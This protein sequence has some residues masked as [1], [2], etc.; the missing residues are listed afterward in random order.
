MKDTVRKGIIVICGI[1]LNVVGRIIAIWLGLP[2][3]FDM[4]GTIL[5]A[6]Y[7]GLWG[8]LIAGVSN[9]LILSF[10][11]RTALVYMLIS[12]VAA[13]LLNFFIKKGYM[14][15]L[16]KAV[17]SSFWIG[18][19]CTVVSTP[20]N[21]IFYNGYS[22]NVWGDTLVDMLRWY[23]FPDVLAALAGETVV[24]IVDK[25][26]TVLA[27]YLVI[28]LLGSI[29]KKK[30]NIKQNI[31][32]LL[33]VGIASAFIINPANVQAEEDNLFV[34]NFVENIYDSKNGMVSSEANAI[35]ET[36]DG[37]IWIGSYAGLTR[38]NGKDFEFVR[39]GGLV[40]VVGM[41]TDS[42]GRL[43]I[44]TNDA[45]I[46]RY[47]NGEYTYFT[48]DDGL[49]SDSVRCFAEDEKGNVYVGT[50]D[51]ICR[52][53]TDDTIQILDV[54][55]TFAKAMEVYQDMLI[56]VDNKGEIHAVNCSTQAEIDNSKT[57]DKFYY[58]LASTSKGL[59]AGTETGELFIADISE[60]TVSVKEQI[61]I[62]GNQ[63]SAVF[64]DSRKRLWVALNS[65]F[66]YI[67]SNGT[68]HKMHYDGFD[69]SIVSFHED[70][71]GNIWVASSHYG[72]MKLSE[73][74]FVNLFEKAGIEKAYVNAVEYFDGDYYCAMDDGI[75]ILDGD[76]LTLK[77]NIASET[78][79]GYRVRSF[80]KDSEDRLWI[81]TYSGL[82]CYDKQDGISSF[83]MQSHNIT[84]ERFRCITQLSDG[85]IAAGTA[86]GINFIKNGK[87]TATFD[88]EDGLANTQ[89][90]SIVE[91]IDGT[92]WAG[93]DG[94]GIY[95][96]SEGKL[97]KNYTVEDGLS[98]NI[99]LRI[100][101]HGDGYFIVTSNALCHVDMDGTIRR[102]ES[103]PY[104]NNY[105]V[106]ING[107]T[108]YVTCSAGLYEVQL[109]KLCEDNYEQLRY[110]GAGTGLFSGLTANSWNYI[111]EDGSL[112]LCS[113]SG[114]IVYN[115]RVENTAADMKYGIVSFECD[116][117]EIKS[118]D[119]KNFVVPSNTKN[120]SIYASVKN[121]AFEEVKVR[122]YIKEIEDNPKVCRWDE[123]ESIRL[124]KPDLSE[125][126]VCL[127]ILD[128]SGENILQETEYTIS[129][130]KQMWEKT[131]YKTYLVLVCTEI[132]LF[133]IISIVIMILF[134]TR[135]Y[136]LEK[137]Q[138]ELEQKV[139]EQTGELVRKQQTIKEL[140][141]QTVTALSEAV[142][143]KDRYTSG[144]SKR[145][146]EY[147]RMIA[148]RMGK[149]KEEQ[150]L[151]YRAGLLH[152]V[153]KIRIP[154]EIINKP[155]KLTDEEYNIMK[156]HP[157]TG[158]HI[159]R[160]ITGSEMIAI[161][162]KYHHERYDGKGYPNGLIGEKIPE[163]AR[164][165]GIAD[166]Y[167]AMTSNR[168]YRNA[169]PQEVVRNEIVKGRGTQF[170]P[171]VAD[172]M[173]QM[174]DE[175]MDYKLKQEEFTH[176]RILAVDDEAMNNRIIAHIMKEEPMYEIIPASSGKQALEIIEQQT[177]DLILLDV[178]MPEMDGLETLRLIRKKYQTPVVLMTADKTLD[179]ST[180][181]GELGCDDFITKPFLPLLLKEIIHNM[182][183]RTN[184]KDEE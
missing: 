50:S 182:T 152:D 86:D 169:L 6:Y 64:E 99:I 71:Q 129:K 113:N 105:D 179:T 144:H 168:S 165:L 138:I 100:V 34:D 121:Y 87:V 57:K 131:G 159:L 62:P 66:G 77:S 45:G 20:L 98:S 84:S 184:I 44:G 133:T 107:E 128:A 170:D 38:Y 122:F 42:S 70:Y 25:Q 155:G 32:T 33:V 55:I 124:Y 72:V 150:E 63:I 1:L 80:Y 175:D 43:W 11:D 127:Q 23:D 134:I 73:S 65:D 178:N 101:P 110:Y 59:I 75:K 31:A 139:K 48:S 53:N 26:I 15:N 81:C 160:G 109:S 117:K 17:V 89:I 172:I 82:F 167:D 40:N 180:E 104:F 135:K 36:N 157:V 18:L 2:I 177:F 30:C 154:N 137:L 115:N 39:E 14:N 78:V 74:T 58:C 112:Y 114:V 93:S 148:A 161:A 151:I 49:P 120:L 156:I 37:Y 111:S 118:Q 162:A 54:N 116:G 183:E 8:G 90:L 13:F 95:V 125:Y 28:C 7:V 142:D 60:H 79:K 103:F 171:E 145:V 119:G 126:H 61:D 163:V 132:F 68:Y 5:A 92:V 3:W 9:N 19:I 166:A 143:A 97:I 12:M 27:A 173:L 56:I 147:S 153:G 46:A 29:K 164:I 69:S 176:K 83:R 106:I 94:S 10:Y 4:M 158:Y 22:G 67:D 41:M 91:G 136:E 123:M 85:T 141:I 174:I 130:E 24:E 35:C 181:Y 21:L 149:N 102:L 76:N 146:A 88:T 140:Y 51:K 47:E 52:F 108:A 96:I 16:L